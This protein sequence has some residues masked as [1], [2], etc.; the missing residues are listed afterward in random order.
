M[1]NARCLITRSLTGALALALHLLCLPSVSAEE[2]VLKDKELVQTDHGRQLLKYIVSCALPAGMTVVFKV[3][4]ESYALP[5]AMGLAPGWS[6]Q[7]LTEQQ[8]RRVSGCVLARTNFFGIPVLLSMRSETPDMRA[9]LQVD[10][11]EG[12][13]YPFFEAAF[14]GN[15]FKARQEMFVCTGDEPPGRQKHL[16]S[17]LRVCS[18]PAADGK[19]PPGQSRCGFVMAGSCKDPVFHREGTDYSADVMRVYL[20]S[21]SLN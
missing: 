1:T 21:G 20:P 7:A 19:Q 12:R 16:E 4:N 9:V 17:L 2:L 15:I 6:R 18:L 3:D 11:K 10:E 8:E 14:F 5:G 13:D